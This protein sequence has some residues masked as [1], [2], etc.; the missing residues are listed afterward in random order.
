MFITD[1]ILTS[2]DNILQ[3]KFNFLTSFQKH[4]D[5]TQLPHFLFLF[6]T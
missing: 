4:A 1:T 3:P 2:P 5:G 6:F